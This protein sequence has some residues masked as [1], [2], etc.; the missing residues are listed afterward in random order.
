MIAGKYRIL[1]SVGQGGMG[2]VYSAEHVSMRRQVAI[3]V[4][5]GEF[6]SD[7]A[8]AARFEREAQAASRIASP[9]AVT[10]YDFGHGE[11]GRLH[12][13]MELLTGESLAARLERERRLDWQDAAR[14]A[15]QA[16]AG[17][18]A[19]HSAGVVHRDLKPDNVFLCA[20][21]VVKLLDFG[22]A[23]F[24]SRDDAPHGKGIT[25]AG[26]IL[27]TALYMSPEAVARKA[28]GPAADLYALGA[29]LFEMVTGRVVF[30]EEDSVLLMGAHVRMP[31]ERIREV[32]PELELPEEL[33]AL[34]DELLA[35][36]PSTRPSDAALVAARL[37]A[38]VGDPPK[39]KRAP[40]TG[41]HSLPP[42]PRDSGA[43]R[44]VRAEAETVAESGAPPEMPISTLP[45]R[46]WARW[47]ALGLLLAAAVGGGGAAISLWRGESPPA[48]DDRVAST[49]AAAPRAAA[50][51]PVAASPSVEPPPAPPT[52]APIETV[53]LRVVV[54][55]PRSGATVLVDGE[56]DSDG[57]LRVPRD[58][59]EHVF[60]ARAR[61]H[62]DTTVT[63]TADGEHEEIVRLTPT[64][65]TGRATADEASTSPTKRG[66]MA[67]LRDY[68]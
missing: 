47:L 16:C 23:R 21:G 18:A 51:A 49:M 41:A 56:P 53:A 50:V 33:D 38:L 45:A 12:L 13:V 15:V 19:A 20:D 35:K 6:A 55:R 67:P 5:R 54:E 11:D 52:T 61:G 39:P 59:S 58:G 46:S 31:P 37:E 30:E 24:V 27:G 57:E 9:H 34:V 3:K 60:V 62:R 1:A 32:R 44:A 40:V 64:G 65:S 25:Q 14:I 43:T 26:M 66:G 17:L 4:M 10:I 8:M 42:G 2:A 29:M 28:V 48:A 63:L 7:A 22:I 68:E 36:D